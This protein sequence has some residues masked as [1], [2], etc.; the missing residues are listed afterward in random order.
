MINK[1]I[2]SG[3]LIVLDGID[4]SGKSTQAGI[5]TDWMKQ[6]GYMVEKI[7]FP[8]YNNK[9]SGLVEEY[10]NGK[11]G[12]ADT[13]D[14]Y[15]AS[16]FYAADRYDASFKIKKWLDSGKIVIADRYASANMAHQGGK[17]KKEGERKKFLKW[18]YNLEFN[19]FKIPRPETTLILHVNSKL[20]HI[21]SNKR[22]AKEWKEK[23]RD[24][25][26]SSLSHLENSERIYLQIA[27]IFKDISLI[28]C[29]PEG[30]LLPKQEIQ[31]KI[32]KKLNI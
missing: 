23:T 29:S 5:L 16:I 14:P 30:K 4:G 20:A 18:L 6:K 2:K 3:K 9:S 12:D 7:H 13:V 25:H 15:V 1:A 22:K 10:I 31:K 27:E 11:Y 19:I 21:L 32:I 28:E 26:E 17:I 8:Q 24:I